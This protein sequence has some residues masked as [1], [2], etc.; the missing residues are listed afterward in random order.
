VSETR[1]NGDPRDGDCWARRATQMCSK[2]SQATTRRGRGREESGRRSEARPATW[3]RSW[4]GDNDQGFACA[5]LGPHS[6]LSRRERLP[7]ALPHYVSRP[8]RLS[9][10]QLVQRAQFQDAYLLHSPC[11][12]G[13]GQHRRPT[14]PLVRSTT[15][16]SATTRLTTCSCV[17][18]QSDLGAPSRRVRGHRAQ[19]RDM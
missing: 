8:E 10:A 3:A 7:R 15:T 19:P 9:S 4:P 14:S 17:H 5:C 2:S 11:L 16:C 12:A 13:S 1:A 18:R 6:K